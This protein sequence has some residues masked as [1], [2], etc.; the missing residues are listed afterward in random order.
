VAGTYDK[1]GRMLAY[2]FRASDG[3][4]YNEFMIAQGYAHEYTYAS[5][6]YKYRDEFRAAQAAAEKGQLGFWSPSACGGNTTKPASTQ[7]S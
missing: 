7:T 3:L 2:V 5:Q 1:Y 6:K 4:F